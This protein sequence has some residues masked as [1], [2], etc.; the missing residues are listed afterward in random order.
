MRLRRRRLLTALNDD[1]IAPTVATFPL[2]G[3]L[4][5]D[6]TVPPTK[7]GGPRTDSE[8]IGDEWSHMD[9]AYIGGRVSAEY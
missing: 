4:G 3:A 5:D 9:E 7:V 6:G 2:L 1:E 8:Y